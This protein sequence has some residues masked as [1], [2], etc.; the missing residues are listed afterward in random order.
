MRT[1]GLRWVRVAPQFAQP[2]VLLKTLEELHRRQGFAACLTLEAGT[3]RR[4]T[5]R[6]VRFAARFAA[7]ASLARFFAILA[8]AR[9]A[10]SCF[11][12]G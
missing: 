12:E 3:F 11:G 5:E 9:R 4:L 6:T 2:P 8:K 7:R 1:L 10:R